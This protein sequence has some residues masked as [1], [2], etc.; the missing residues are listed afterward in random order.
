M[1]ASLKSKISQ[2]MNEGL[3]NREILKEVNKILRSQ[4][5]DTLHYT[6]L[7]KIINSLVDDLTPSYSSDEED[8][9]YVPSESEEEDDDSVSLVSE[10][11]DDS[12]DSGVSMGSEESEDNEDNEDEWTPSKEY[13][14][15]FFYHPEAPGEYDRLTI[16][17]EDGAFLAR[18]KFNMTDTTKPT[19][20]DEFVG[21]KETILE[22]VGDIFR[23][24]RIDQK[25]FTEIEFQIPFYPTISVTPA[26]LNRDTRKT[27]LRIMGV[28]LDHTQLSFD[29]LCNEHGI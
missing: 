14:S 1:S 16:H 2:M 3:S 7:C 22:Y 29:D 4:G 19:K 12:D 15:I 10:A 21:T 18:Y 17:A 25:P 8:E 27:I 13:M 26:R 11:S 23:L 20:I 9:E 6:G 24:L 28:Y 5:K